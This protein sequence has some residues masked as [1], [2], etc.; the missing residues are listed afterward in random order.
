[1][2]F[3]QSMNPKI[4]ALNFKSECI[5]LGKL[6]ELLFPVPLE[7]K[8]GKYHQEKVKSRPQ[9]LKWWICEMYEDYSKSNASYFIL[10]AHNIPDGYWWYSSRIWTRIPTDIPLHFPAMWQMAAKGQPNKMTT[11]VGVQMKRRC[12]NEFLHEDEWH[13]LTFFNAWWTFMETKRWW[14]VSAVVTV[15]H[16]C[17]HRLLWVQ[18]AGSCWSLAKMHT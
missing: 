11:D 14:C 18:H 4:F 5:T 1:M 10:L 8:Y 3:I 13:P 15:G 9:S 7:R 12:V 16:L 17:R 2:N 6:H